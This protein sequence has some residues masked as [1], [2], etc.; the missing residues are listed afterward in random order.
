MHMLMLSMVG[1]M[2]ATSGIT[3]LDRPVDPAPPRTVHLVASEEMKFD[4][5]EIKAQP[6]ESVRIVLRAKGTLPKTVMAHNFV[7]LKAGTNPQAFVNASATAR[8]TGFIAP[9]V[10]G[11]VLAST[12]LAGAGET[13]QV[14]F[15]APSKPGRYDFLCSFPGHFASGMRGVLSVR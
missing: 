7:L 2:L 6:G 10:S 4:I 15:T 1:L 14:T 11:Q 12:P 3:A 8:A 9:A 5:T 13:V